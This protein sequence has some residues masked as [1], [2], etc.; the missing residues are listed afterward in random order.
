MGVLLQMVASFIEREDT[1]MRNFVPGSQ[2]FCV[3]L[4]FVATGQ[5]FEDL[6]FAT[7]IPPET[8]S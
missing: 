2:R 1:V 3:T 7:S 8:L 5:A 4:P 6:K